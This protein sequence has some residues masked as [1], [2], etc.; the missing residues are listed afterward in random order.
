MEVRFDK[1][2]LSLFA[3]SER[4]AYQLALVAASKELDNRAGYTKDK[5][6]W[7]FIGMEHLEEIQ[8]AYTSKEQTT[9]LDAPKNVP[10]FIQA[11]RFKN[12]AIQVQ[13]G[14]TA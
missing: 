5:Y 4:E 13:L 8:G 12:A 6:V 10:A 1:H 2:F 3:G 11:L 7:E 9:I 14:L